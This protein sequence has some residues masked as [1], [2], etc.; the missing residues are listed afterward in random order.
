MANDPEILVAFAQ[1]MKNTMSPGSVDVKLKWMIAN[2]V[3]DL[4]KC[5]YCVGVTEMMLKSFGADE[6]LLK[7]IK[8][9]NDLTPAESAAFEYAKLLTEGAYRIRDNAFDRLEDH[10]NQEQIM[11]ITAVACLF[12]Y[13][14]RF[15]DA[16]RVL[17]ENKSK[18]K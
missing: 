18:I 3:S 7:K 15:N 5:I 16:L 11:E 4:N 10:F 8:N 14:N 1:L 17:P 6:Q 12:N 9:H 13:I 2:E